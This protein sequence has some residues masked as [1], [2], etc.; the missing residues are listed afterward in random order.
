MKTGT[1]PSGSIIVKIE[2]KVRTRK[3]QSS[4]IRQSRSHL[5]VAEVARLPCII[6]DGTLG[7]FRYSDV[8]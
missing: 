1:F 2:T 6:A 5:H 3:G 4:D 8:E 7:E